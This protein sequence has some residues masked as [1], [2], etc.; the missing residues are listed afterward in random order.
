MER[1]RGWEKETWK[2]ERKKERKKVEGEWEGRVVLLPSLSDQGCQSGLGRAWTSCPAAA[3]ATAAAAAATAWPAAPLGG[4]SGGTL[5]SWPAIGPLPGA[6]NT[7]RWYTVRIVHTGDRRWKDR[8][9]DPHET[10]PTAHVS[11]V[12]RTAFFF[13]C[14]L[15]S[16]DIGCCHN[17]RNKRTTNQWHCFTKKKTNQDATDATRRVIGQLAMT[18]RGRR[19]SS[20]NHRP[21]KSES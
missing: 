12:R 3:A 1:K 2:K 11:M 20:N 19:L 18:S 8:P 7:T 13:C 6:H 21:R 17:I 14:A 9:G 5:W 4:K 15:K 10:H 16:P